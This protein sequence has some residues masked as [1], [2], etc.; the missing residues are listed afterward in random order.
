[1]NTKIHIGIYVD[2]DNTVFIT[3]FHTFLTIIQEDL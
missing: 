2:S 3:L 1:M